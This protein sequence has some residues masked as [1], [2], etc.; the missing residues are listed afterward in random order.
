MRKLE[1]TIS[2]SRLDFDLRKKG[3][4]IFF[5]GPFLS[6]FYDDNG[7]EYLLLWVD[8]NDTYNRWILFEIDAYLL[9]C[10][11]IR[12]YSLRDL[13]FK[14]KIQIVYII[15]YDSELNS[16]RIFLINQ[17]EIP[18]EYLPNKSSHFHLDFS[19]DY[20][21]EL[22]KEII[23]SFKRHRNRVKSHKSFRSFP[24]K[25][26]NTSKKDILSRIQNLRNNIYVI[27]ASRF[28][29][30]VL[31][32]KYSHNNTYHYLML[33]TE[34]AIHN[35]VINDMYFYELNREIE[36]FSST[37]LS[38]TFTI[39]KQEIFKNL[40]ILTVRIVQN[41]PSYKS[42]FKVWRSELLSDEKFSKDIQDILETAQ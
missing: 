22:S 4:L 11:F 17:K 6:H 18:E 42:S 14:N 21:K 19:T 25:Y 8:K 34:I 28:P 38:R 35:P 3:D 13:V 40:V 9:Y 24:V 12:K 23:Q 30:E 41:D 7:K 16:K 31:N 20:A 36:N 26:I 33:K 27:E 10:Y 32:D 1:N 5:E 2:L 29:L 39:D 37:K 15:D